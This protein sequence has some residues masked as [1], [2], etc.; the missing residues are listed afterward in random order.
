M[1]TRSPDATLEVTGDIIDHHTWKPLRLKV[2]V[3]TVTFRYGDL[4]AVPEPYASR[5]RNLLDHEGVEY[6]GLVGYVRRHGRLPALDWAMVVAF[7]G[8]AGAGGLSNTLFSNYARDKGWG[9]GA[10][11]GAI[12]SAIGGRTIGLSHTGC[13]FPLDHDNLVRWKRWI[14]H[15]RRDQAIWVLASIMGMALPCMM[16]LEFIRNATVTGDRVAAMTAMGIALRYPNYAGLFWVLT[17][18]CGFLVLAPGQVSVCDQIARRW[19]DMIWTASPRVK[20][21]GQGEVRYLYYGILLGYG[22][23]GLVV[24]WLL[25]ALQ[26]AKI[27]AVLGNVALGVSSFQ[28]LYVNRRLLPPSLRPALW[29]QLG[30]AF[31]GIFFM[32]ISIGVIATL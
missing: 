28:A 26:I 6:V 11:V 19:T 12:P 23:W 7:I 31:C 3:G 9:M 15:I 17:L 4:S 5:F 14:N 1:Q 24:L 22:V 29:M 16:S 13:V 32:G 21:L 20:R 10:R 2:Q 30:V 25:P 27:G 18:L 8:I